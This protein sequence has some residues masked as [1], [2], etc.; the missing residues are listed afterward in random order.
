MF[1]DYIATQHH[2][3]EAVMTSGAPLRN[4]VKDF[5]SIEAELPVKKANS[6]ETSRASGTWFSSWL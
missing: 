1:T 2:G 5:S 3:W 6:G 4:F